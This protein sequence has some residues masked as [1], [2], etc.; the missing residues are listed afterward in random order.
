MI[1][2]LPL[3]RSLDPPK[4]ELPPDGQE[5]NDLGIAAFRNGDFGLAMLRFRQAANDDKPAPRALF[6]RAQANIAVGKYRD[7]VEIIQEGLQAQPNWPISGFNPRAELYD[8]QMNEW[9]E[10]RQRLEQTLLK[11]PKNADYLFLL[12]YLY[13]FDGERGVAVD[14]FQQSRVLGTE[15][16]WADAFLKAAK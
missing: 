1:A 3:C 14:Y 10:H 16:R 4:I 12:G 15:P 11:N 5:L 2:T 8:N 9:K 6:L 7:A 13:W